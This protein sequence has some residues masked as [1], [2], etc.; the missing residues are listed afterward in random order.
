MAEIGY[1]MQLWV[2][3]DEAAVTA[4]VKLAE[5]TNLTPPALEASEVETTHT[6]SPNAIRQFIP[7]LS[8]PGSLEVEMNWAPE[9]ATDTLIRDMMFGRET[10]YMEIRFTQYSP[11]V[12]FGGRGFFMSYTP[13]APLD[14]RMTA[15]AN[16][17]AAGV[18][19]YT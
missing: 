18:W 6:D 15:T 13:G 9:S 12:V 10:R 3:A 14:D 1:G 16:V 19:D 7:G 11:E 4:T 8:D 2:A 5:I 17:R